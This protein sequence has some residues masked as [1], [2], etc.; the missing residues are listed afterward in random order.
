MTIDHLIEQIGSAKLLGYF[1][2]DSEEWHEAR[3]GVAGSLVGS[4][5]GHNPWRSAYT[6]Y[7]EYLGLLPRE[8]NGPSLAMRLGTAFEKPIQEL[9]VQENSEWLTAH[10]TGTWASTR[11][12]NFKANPDA[13]IEWS[14]GSLGI[15]EIKFS[16]NPMNE[17]PPHYKDQV[18]WYLHVLG[19]DRG[20]LVAVANG[21][22]VEHEIKYDVVY[23]AELEA[24]AN[25]FLNRIETQV[26]PDWDGS[27]STYETVRTL[28]DQLHDDEVELG[29]LYQ[30]LIRAKENMDDAD[31][32]LTLL[33]SQVLHLM[34]GA[35]VGTFEGD[36]VIQLQVRGTGAPFIVFKRG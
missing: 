2:H 14:D 18:M 17:L 19:L 34:D 36:K 27:Q 26:P 23:A 20:V 29:E 12:P 1:A 11:N 30:S 22:L 16:R 13:I 4:L 8:S 33:K 32:R 10:N 31:Q 7:H 9:W 21:E 35:R 6:A 3:K 24:M 28:S 25:E 15:L 5:M